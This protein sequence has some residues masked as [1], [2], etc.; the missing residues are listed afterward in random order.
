MQI[1]YVRGKQTVLRVFSDGAETA[2]VA[3]S[4]IRTKERMHQMMR[5]QGFE[6]KSEEER[7]KD[8][9]NANRIRRQ[10]NLAMFHR[11]EYLR[12][13]HLHAHLFREDVMQDTEYYQR[14][15]VYKDTDFLL[16]NYDKI[17]RNEAVYNKQLLE[18]ATRYLVKVGRL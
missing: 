8:V 6:L 3:L 15:W 13:Q 2:V 17:F 16:E 5:E 9:E 4:S 10:R 11:K 7:N 14:S 12:K 1:K 18:Y